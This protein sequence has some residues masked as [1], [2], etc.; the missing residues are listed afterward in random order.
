MG[1]RER[2]EPV[3]AEIAVELEFVIL[4]L[5]PAPT[6]LLLLPPEAETVVVVEF[7][8]TIIHHSRWRAKLLSY[9]RRHVQSFIKK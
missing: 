7:V 2:R 3:L 9:I 4:I 8:I 5:P 1:V 6:V